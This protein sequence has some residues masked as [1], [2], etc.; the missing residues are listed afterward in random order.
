MPTVLAVVEL[1]SPLRPLPDPV[2]AAIKVIRRD[3]LGGLIHEHPRSHRMA[4]FGT[5]R[6]AIRCLVDPSLIG[7]WRL[8]FLPWPASCLLRAFMNVVH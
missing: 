8:D 6:A 3:R 5:A 1:G 2:D 7:W 4:E